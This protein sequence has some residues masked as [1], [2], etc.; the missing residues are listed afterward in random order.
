[1]HSEKVNVLAETDLLA[2]ES[3]LREESSK[4]SDIDED[5]T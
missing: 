1:L 3:S 2:R 5:E 4:E